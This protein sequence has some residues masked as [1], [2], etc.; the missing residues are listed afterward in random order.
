MTG[1]QLSG[2]LAVGGATDALE[3]GRFMDSSTG[4]PGL[5][6]E[7]AF[8]TAPDGT[9]P[10]WVN[11]SDR[12]AV[13]LGITIT[14]GRARPDDAVDPGTLALTLDN[15]DGAFVLGSSYFGADAAGRGNVKIGRRIRVRSG[16][17][18]LFDGYVDAWPTTWESGAGPCL[19]PITA[20][21]LL[22]KL[23][24]RKLRSVLQED[25]LAASPWAYW[26]LAEG[27]GATSFANISG[28]TQGPLTVVSYG[29]GG[30]LSNQPTPNGAALSEE[31]G[32]W[33]ELAAT[34]TTVGAALTADLTL[35]ASALTDIVPGVPTAQYSLTCGFWYAPAGTASDREVLRLQNAAGRTLVVVDLTADLKVRL[36][37]LGSDGTSLGQEVS[38]DPLAAAWGTPLLIGV[39]VAGQQIIA[40]DLTAFTAGRRQASVYGP[41]SALWDVPGSVVLGGT[42]SGSGLGTGYLAHAFLCAN[43]TASETFQPGLQLP[44]S[45]SVQALFSALAT[46]AVTAGDGETSSQRVARYARYA[47]A[48]TADLG[49]GQTSMAGARAAKAPLLSGAYADPQPMYTAPT[50]VT[51]LGGQAALEAL[52]TAE[53]A[54]A[55][56]LLV[57]PAGELAFQDRTHRWKSP[58]T[59]ALDFE[60]L[61]EGL[62]FGGDDSVLVNAVT[63][64]R[65]GGGTVTVT[66][67]DSIA[68]YGEHATTLEVLVRDDAALAYAGQYHLAYRSQPRPYVAGLTMDLTTL[69]GT[70]RSPRPDVLIQPDA[71]S[72]DSVLHLEISDRIGLYNVPA[73]AGGDPDF[74]GVPATFG[75]MRLLVVEG[76]TH[77]ISSDS[78]TLALNT[79]PGEPTLYGS[80]GT[81]QLSLTDPL[82]TA[83]ASTLRLNTGGFDLQPADVAL[84]S[85]GRT[86]LLDYHD[87]NYQ[88]TG[89]AQT[90][91]CL[92]GAQIDP[93]NPSHMT[94]PV[95]SGLR[96]SGSLTSGGGQVSLVY[97]S[98]TQLTTDGDAAAAGVVAGMRVAL[99][100]ATARGVDAAADTAAMA[101]DDGSSYWAGPGGVLTVASVSGNVVTLS[102]AVVPGTP[103]ATYTALLGSPFELAPVVGTNPDGSPRIG[104]PFRAG[105]AAPAAAHPVD[106]P[107]QGGAAALLW[108][109]DHSAPFGGSGSFQVSPSQLDSPAALVAF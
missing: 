11:I 33:V 26:P 74:L 21:D 94:V 72:W 73:S 63:V 3:Q 103:A 71:P 97:T 39:T 52:G 41:P 9:D 31:F 22:K 81:E 100:P 17:Q 80:A 27:D 4:V 36:T 38:A 107:T 50:T 46:D 104:L 96:V 67:A 62:S 66:D 40:G 106:F 8:A 32:P 49:I 95:T 5:T 59:F 45:D 18:P 48:R 98:A 102:T 65:P 20:T 47:G 69:A 34:S 30:Y 64:T 23:A 101:A 86:L 83:G 70:V 51:P 90:V 91:W 87:D 92:P 109:Y 25:V 89:Q 2:A 16:S 79:S 37:V 56:L 55:G 7:V 42:K 93:A 24:T 76:Y 15:S 99:I 84:L 29:S 19:A 13:D 85:A 44:L 54:E 78:W 77:T 12:V 105:L 14:R 108:T 35:P 60:W 68:D 88:P 43:Q 58:L 6:V 1:V 57:T 53:A 82:P 10:A 28:T 75:H 61:A